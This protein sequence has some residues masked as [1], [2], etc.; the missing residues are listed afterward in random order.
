M[1]TALRLVMFFVVFCLSCNR[2]NDCIIPVDYAAYYKGITHPTEDESRAIS[3][4]ITEDLQHNT[5][6]KRM[7]SIKVKDWN[8]K[9]IRLNKL[10]KEGSILIFSTYDGSYGAE[11]VEKV[12]PGMLRDLEGEMEDIRVICLVEDNADNKKKVEEYVWKLTTEYSNVYLI[13]PKDAARINLAATPTKFYVNNEGIVVHL[14]VGYFAEEQYR[15][16]DLRIG[17]DKIIQR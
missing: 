16:Q 17:V 15:E 2:S 13:D 1:R 4:R 9:S 3:Q 7:P 8:G 6:G 14:S 10:M 5:L 11:E 12:L